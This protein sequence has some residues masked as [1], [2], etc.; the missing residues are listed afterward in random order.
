MSLAGSDLQH[1]F[2]EA[3]SRLARGDLNSFIA[4]ASRFSNIL[5]LQLDP[6]MYFYKSSLLERSSESRS[7]I[8]IELSSYVLGNPLL[9]KDELILEAYRLKAEAVKLAYQIMLE[10]VAKLEEIFQTSITRIVSFWILRDVQFGGVFLRGEGVEEF[11]LLGSLLAKC[12]LCKI[13]LREVEPVIMSAYNLY[14]C[15]QALRAAISLRKMD[16]V[17]ML[18]KA[19]AEFRTNYVKINSNVSSKLSR[20]EETYEEDVKLQYEL[21]RYWYQWL[22]KQPNRIPAPFFIIPKSYWSSGTLPRKGLIKIRPVR[23]P[24][25]AKK[26]RTVLNAIYGVLGSGKTMLLNSLAVYRLDQGG[27][28]LRLEIDHHRRFQAQLMAAPLSPKHPA[29]D[30]V[31]H[32]E[33]L[34]PRPIDVLSL[35][36]VRGDSDLKY[37]NPPLRIDRILYV[38][39]PMSFHLGALWEKLYKPGRLICLKFVTMHVTGAAY[40]SL[41]KSFLEFRASHRRYPMFVQ[42]EEALMG[43]A[44][45]VSMMYSRSMLI[46]SE[47]VEILV[48]GL[49]GLGLAGDFSTQRPSY[50]ISS[51]RGQA[52]NIFTGHMPPQDVEVVFENLPRK[53]EFETARQVLSDGSV[54]FNDNYKWFLWIDKSSGSVNYIRSMVPPCGAEISD[55]DPAEIFDE[56]NL[57]AES[58]SRVPHLTDEPLPEYEEFLPEKERTAARKAR[59]KEGRKSE[60]SLTI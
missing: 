29:Y 20:V 9:F 59:R 16:Y 11:A 28:G 7:I 23:F 30:Y 3:V 13:P 58:W 44:A 2:E 1:L 31:V 57:L 40:T 10:V 47:E 22:E 52:S 45:K 49:R 55:M 50:I 54:S 53:G 12:L 21:H 32:V 38:E 26:G 39:N 35:V 36:I 43:A 17:V 27:F 14:G 5:N 51:A 42:V 46:S 25:F 6:T 24:A 41:L 18:E 15:G 37:A 4:S 19:R 34:K 48:Q 60:F 33:K 56:Y 8:R